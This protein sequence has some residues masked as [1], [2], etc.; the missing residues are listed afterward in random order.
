MWICLRLDVRTV[1]WEKFFF[2]PGKLYAINVQPLT[3]LFNAYLHFLSNLFTPPCDSHVKGIVAANC[4]K[5]RFLIQ[6]YPTIRF[7]PTVTVAV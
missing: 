6:I 1:S 3:F 2:W 7:K 4:K 5:K